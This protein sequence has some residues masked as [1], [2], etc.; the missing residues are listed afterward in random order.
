MIIDE[1]FWIKSQR[2]E[3]KKKILEAGAKPVLY[4][5]ECPVE[6]MRGRVISRSKSPQVDSFEITGEMFDG[7]LK[8]WEPPTK[9]EGALVSY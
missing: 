5:V 6:E 2:D 8:Y 3:I 1:G 4:Y 9:S 7:Y